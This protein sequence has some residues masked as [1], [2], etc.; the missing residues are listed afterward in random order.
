MFIELSSWNSLKQNYI[1]NKTFD[2]IAEKL[3]ISTEQYSFE[4]GQFNEEAH[5]CI[6]NQ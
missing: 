3:K 6:N 2:F 5:T 4:H 1:R